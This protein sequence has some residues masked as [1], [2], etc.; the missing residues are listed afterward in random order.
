M[1]T[2]PLE[3]Q[4]YTCFREL[5]EEQRKALAQIATEE[6][7][8]DGHT[9]FEEGKPGTHIFL[10]GEGQVEVLY[11]IGEGFLQVDRAGAGEI[12]GC[13]A[14]VDPYTYTSTT[15]CCTDIKVMT[16][17]AEALLKLMKDDCPLGFSILKDIIQMLL[18]RIID[19]RLGI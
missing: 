2:D 6:F 12:V 8:N 16:M 3:L 7:F 1:L 14:L 11:Y 10:I 4:K 17:E 5:T 9:L 19:L 15:R 13:S 18:D